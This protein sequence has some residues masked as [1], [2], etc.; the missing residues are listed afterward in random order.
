[1]SVGAARYGIVLRPRCEPRDV[2][3]LVEDGV[4]CGCL[5]CSYRFGECEDGTGC[6]DRIIRILGYGATTLPSIT[7]ALTFEGNATLAE[8]EASRV[9]ALLDKLTETIKV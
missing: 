3:S 6:A 4:P 2:G 9:S 7:E 8:Q 5:C 1:M